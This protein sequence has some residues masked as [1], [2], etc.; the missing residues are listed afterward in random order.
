MSTE[1]TRAELRLR[2]DPWL[3]RGLAGAVE[4]FA[5]R[6]ELSAEEQ[7]DLISATAEACQNTFQLLAEN[8][9]TLGI[10]LEDFADRI[11]ITLEHRGAALPS[12]GLETFAGFGGEGGEGGDLSG[13]MLLSRVD[14]VLYNTENGVSRM[15]LVKYRHAAEEK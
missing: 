1:H 12:A 7:Q 15:T 8:D 2:N 14:R 9:G 4:H 6:G 10:V 5:Q 3:L 11:E 13:L